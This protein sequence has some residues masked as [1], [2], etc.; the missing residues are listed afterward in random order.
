MIKVNGK[1]QQLSPDRLTKVPD[2]SG[3]KAWVS[4]PVKKKRF[5]EVLDM[6]GGNMW[7]VREAFSE[8]ARV[9]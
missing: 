5:A 1:L 4:P 9:S 2:P 8:C 3:M 6:G 7:R